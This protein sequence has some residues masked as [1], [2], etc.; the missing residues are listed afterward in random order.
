MFSSVILNY[1]VFYLL[2]AFLCSVGLSGLLY[3]YSKQILHLPLYLKSIL[4]ALRCMSIFLLFVILLDVQW[5]NKEHLVEDP[6]IVFLQDNSES[7]INNSDSLFY[8]IDYVNYL[9]SIKSNMNINYYNF[10]NSLL[11]QK[12]DFKSQSTNISLSLKELVGIYDNLNVTAYILASDG[13]YNEGFNPLYSNINL[14]APLY[15]VGLGDTTVFQDMSLSSIRNNTISYLGNETPVELMV[16]AKGMEG[17]MIS[18]KVYNDTEDPLHLLPIVNEKIII[19]NNDFYKKIR[20]FVQPKN[21]K[22]NH[23][24]AVLSSNI[25]EKN[26]DNNKRKFFIDV[27]DNRKKILLLFSTPHPDVASIKSSLITQDEYELETYLITDFID[28]MKTNN[29]TQYLDQYSLVI[30]HQIPYNGDDILDDLKGVPVWFIVGQNTSLSKFNFQQN[31]ITFNDVDSDFDFITSSLNDSFSSFLFSDSLAR[32]FTSSLLVPF[33]DFSVNSV[34]D[35]L[36]FKTIGSMNTQKPIFFFGDN[37]MRQAILLGEGLWRLRLHDSFLHGN[38]NLFNNFINKVTQ[39]LVIDKDKSRLRLDYNNLQYSNQKMTI[40]AELYNASFELINSEDLQL[41]V[42][43]SLGNQF[44]YSFIPIDNTYTLDLGFLDSGRYDFIATVEVGSDKIVKKGYFRISNFAME[45]YDV[46][47]NHLLLS[48]LSSQHGGS[49]VSL[50][51]Y[52]GLGTIDDL[53]DKIKNSPSYQEVTYFNNIIK[54]L[55]NFKF[56]LILILLLLCIE[57]WIRRI[58][59][60]Y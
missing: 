31:L 22:L 5:K 16:D 30:C 47:A 19:S 15:T 56:L 24:S 53:L 23:F 57:W 7:I 40:N 11:H 58:Y 33:S 41:S 4:F 55:I 13:I 46:V 54:P 42:L 27:I 52:T 59:I 6:I 18:L 60:N 50:T 28:M 3:F 17:E 26:R 32:I 25:I 37:N 39:Y 1:S 2:L 21:S 14:R 38:N 36:S 9:D 43:D 35:V 10:G 51:N 8:K 45:S 34:L 20:F 48:N 49:H 44:N 29:I 12:I